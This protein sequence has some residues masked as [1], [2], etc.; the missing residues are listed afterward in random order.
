MPREKGAGGHLK[1]FVP[2]ELVQKNRCSLRDYTRSAKQKAAMNHFPMRENL[3]ARH[4]NNHREGVALGA[5]ASLWKTT[6]V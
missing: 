1:Q 4:G 3:R 2:Y 5:G 6:G